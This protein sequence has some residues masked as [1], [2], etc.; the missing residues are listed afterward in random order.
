[1]AVDLHGEDPDRRA[2]PHPVRAAVRVRA[3]DGAV[4]SVAGADDRFFPLTFQR[5]LARERLGVELEETPG[6]YL[7]ALSQPG[8]VVSALL[9]SA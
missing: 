6:G 9:A 3:L 8:A 4:R 7:A 1:V 5:R 2:G